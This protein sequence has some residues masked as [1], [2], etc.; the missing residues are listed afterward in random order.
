MACMAVRVWLEGMCTGVGEFAPNPG[1]V[2][3]LALLPADGVTGHFR[4]RKKVRAIGCSWRCAGVGCTK[5]HTLRAHEK[6]RVGKPGECVSTRSA[7]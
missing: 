1:T 3:A 4:A 5:W 2:W 7:A 6:H